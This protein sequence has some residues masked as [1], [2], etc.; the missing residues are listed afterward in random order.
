[1][2]TP[3]WLYLTGFALIGAVQ[4]RR[5]AQKAARIRATRGVLLLTHQDRN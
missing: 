2:A 4:Y 1:M 3:I 5:M